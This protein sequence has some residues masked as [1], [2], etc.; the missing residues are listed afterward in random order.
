MAIELKDKQNVDAPDGQYL[1][2]NI[3]DIDA[4]PP[5][6]QGTLLDMV[7]HADY[8]QYFARMFA[9]SGI[10]PNDLPDNDYD[11]FQYYESLIK[12][13]RGQPPAIDVLGTPGRIALPLATADNTYLIDDSDVSIV[14][15]ITTREDGTLIHLLNRDVSFELVI[16]R[17]ASAPPAGFTRFRVGDNAGIFNGRLVIKPNSGATFVYSSLGG[18]CVL[19][20]APSPIFHGKYKALLTQ[21]GTAAPTVSVIENT[22][23]FNIGLTWTRT[24]VGI[25]KVTSSSAL[26]HVAETY[27][28]ISATGGTIAANCSAKRL[29]DT[30]LE[31]RTRVPSTDTL[32]DALL[33]TTPFSFQ[34]PGA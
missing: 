16:E 13:F 21:T 33:L 2:G 6:I 19:I 20:S 8:F 15:Y 11:G 29:S 22:V 32:T 4:G 34:V 17:D 31:V 5:I 10:V 26:F 30:E 14:N 3:R 24:G 27:F 18:G 23:D 25:Y 12:T 28:Q 1:Y 9:L 7:T